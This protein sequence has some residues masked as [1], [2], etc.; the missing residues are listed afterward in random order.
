M[1]KSVNHSHEFP[2]F[3][4]F[5]V[6]LPQNP[7][8]LGDEAS[9]NHRKAAI[10]LVWSK[11]MLHLHSNKKG[12]GLQPPGWTPLRIKALEFGIDQLILGD[13]VFSPPENEW[14]EP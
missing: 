8:F 12:L 3:E 2:R 1:D 11:Q 13:E 5:I 14:M 6:S 10:F 4:G 9:Q 7:P